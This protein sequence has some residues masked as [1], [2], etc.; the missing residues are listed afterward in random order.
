MSTEKCKLFTELTSLT[1][2][3]ESRWM[4]K[5]KVRETSIEDKLSSEKL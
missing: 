3:T 4:Q 5:F 1:R 2:A